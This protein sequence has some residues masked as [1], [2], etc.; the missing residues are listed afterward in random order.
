MITNPFKNNNSD[1][2]SHILDSESSDI[3]NPYIFI[4]VQTECN[5]GKWYALCSRYNLPRNRAN[6]SMSHYSP[7]FDE[8]CPR[9]SEAYTIR[10][11]LGLNTANMFPSESKAKEYIDD[12]ILQGYCIRYIESPG[13]RKNKPRIDESDFF[14]AR[15]N[16]TKIKFIKVNQ[17]ITEENLPEE[18][19]K[20]TI[21]KRAISKLD[22]N[23][24]QLLGLGKYKSYEVLKRS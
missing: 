3:I 4:L 1:H 13:D 22:C 21:I 20:E 19:F 12:I 11:L 18:E 10:L 15:I 2:I 5:A 23:E 17:E 6:S 14:K 9:E 8:T 24:A 16:W 7:A